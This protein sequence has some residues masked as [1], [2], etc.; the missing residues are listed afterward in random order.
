MRAWAA[1]GEGKKKEGLQQMKSAAE[2]EDGTEESA[3]TPGPLEPARELLG[4]MLL[5]L[6]EPA[7]ALDQFEATLKKEPGRFPRTLRSGACGAT[8]RKSRCE[9]NIVSR[10]VA[11]LCS[12]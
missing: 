2:L 7:Q 12:S 8:Q 10:A 11:G 5:E 9:S 1:L 3:V 6:N 4:E